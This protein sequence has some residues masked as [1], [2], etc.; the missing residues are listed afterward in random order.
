[1]TRWWFPLAWGGAGVGLCGLALGLLLL[2]QRLL[3]RPLAE[4]VLAVQLEPGGRL[5]L[6]HQPISAAT[7]HGVLRAAA[8]RSPPPRL[9]LVP[10]ADL[11]WGELRRA[12]QTFD[13]GLLPLELQLPAAA[14]RP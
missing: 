5:R 12:L 14:R 7:L 3:Q 4:G 2:P 9:R 10:S 6:W 1:M 8:R 11:P 13:R